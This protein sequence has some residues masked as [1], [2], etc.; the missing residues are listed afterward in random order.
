[1]LLGLSRSTSLRVLRAT[2]IRHYSSTEPLTRTQLIARLR[3]ATQAPLLR[4]REAIE[5][6]QGD[7]EKAY[8]WLQKE[9]VRLGEEKA[10]RLEGRATGEGVVAALTGPGQR[11]ALV[12]VGS[13]GPH[14]CV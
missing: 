12:E 11:G 8:Q 6:G 4:V 9:M 2:T 3:R 5:Q 1:M 13:D 14:T 10:S 7:Y